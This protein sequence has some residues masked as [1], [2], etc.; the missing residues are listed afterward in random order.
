MLGAANNSDPRA[1]PWTCPCRPQHARTWHTFLA[2]ATSWQM[3]VFLYLCRGNG[4]KGRDNQGN[5]HGVDTPSV[6]AASGRAGP[7]KELG[8]CGVSRTPRVRTWRRSR[9]ASGTLCMGGRICGTRPR[10]QSARKQ[11]AVIVSGICARPRGASP[12]QPDLLLVAGC[13][14]PS[15]ERF[16][17]PNRPGCRRGVA[18]RLLMLTRC[19]LRY[20]FGPKQ[21]SHAMGKSLRSPTSSRSCLLDILAGKRLP[22]KTRCARRNERRSQRLEL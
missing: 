22:T 3:T 1:L 9:A 17:C 15:R 6:D 2:F 10:A 8:L 16:P 14:A 11:A 19:I 18:L 5:G 13:K 20:G 4:D 7:A 12:L 21:L